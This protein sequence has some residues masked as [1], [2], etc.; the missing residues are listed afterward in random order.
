MEQSRVS[1]SFLEPVD[2]TWRE[3]DYH[4]GARSTRMVDVVTLD[5]YARTIE[6]I[7]LLKIDVQGFE[8]EVLRGAVNTLLKIDFILVEA[9]IRP[10]YQ[11]APRFTAVYDFLAD[12]GFHLMTMRAW[13]RGNRTLVETDMLFRRDDLMPPIDPSVDRIMEHV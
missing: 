11:N 9:A 5:E 4:T 12:H 2:A 3:I 1:N 13:H 10:L 6:S 8:L 7:H